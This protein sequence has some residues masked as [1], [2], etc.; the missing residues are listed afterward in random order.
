LSDEIAEMPECPEIS[1]AET[2]A[3]ERCIL[4]AALQEIQ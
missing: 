1:D 4:N 2:G 3:G